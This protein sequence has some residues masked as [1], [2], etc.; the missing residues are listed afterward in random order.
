MVK[1]KT[2]FGNNKSRFNDNSIN[3]S[4]K[5]SKDSKLSLTKKINNDDLIVL[6]S[7]SYENKRAR[8]VIE[9]ES[10]RRKSFQNVT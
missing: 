8:Q 1:I 5:I 2:K 6:L 7:N 3:V 4:G 10:I 9:W